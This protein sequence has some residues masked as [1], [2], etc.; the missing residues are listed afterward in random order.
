MTEI[1]GHVAEGFEAVGDAFESNFEL[2]GDVGAGFSLFVDGE[3]V[4]SLTGGVADADGRP[5]DED[6]LQ[7]VFSTTKGATAICAHLLAERGLL[8]LDAPVVEYWP[9]FAAAGKGDVPVNWLLSHKS[10][11]VDVDRTMSLD[12]ALDWDSV[13]KALAESAP[14]WEPGTQHGYHAITYGF[15]VGEIIRRISGKSIGEFFAD[16]VAA[17][18]GLDFWI[19]LPESEQHRVAPLIPMSSIPEP[20]MLAEEGPATDEAPLSLIAMLEQFLGP[21]NLIGRAL[22][23]PGGAFAEEHAWN[24]PSVRAAQIPAANGVTN[25]TSLARMYSSLVVETDGVRT[26][27][28]ETVDRAIVPQVSGPDSVLMFPIPFALGFMTHS[29][30]SPFLSG[31]S[32]GHG[33]AGGSLGFADP[34]RRIGGGY[35]MNKMHMGLTGDPRN[36]ALL[37][38]VERSVA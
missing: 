20:M 10:G 19:G 13:T 9:E 22:T 25:A 36:I 35:V 38:A 30:F 11:L 2:H 17:P 16:E 24:E 6:T 4:V 12:E 1:R 14:L 31:R 8:D 5:Y 3:E 33:G 28:P 34:D 32:F 21:D 23:A 18:L 15:L 26:L 37:D 7:L 27:Q 29:D